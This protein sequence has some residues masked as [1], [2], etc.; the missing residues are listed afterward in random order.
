M[1]SISALGR[2]LAHTSNL[3]TTRTELQAESI[4]STATNTFLSGQKDPVSLDQPDTPTLLE[5]PA[6]VQRLTQIEPT[7]GNGEWN[8][9]L[10]QALESVPEPSG[11]GAASQG[12]GQLSGHRQFSQRAETQSPH[13]NA[14]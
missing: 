5:R 10:Q 3:P 8:K 9:L 7:S 6:P 11:W 4:L 2:P 14:G 12:L 1:D 13:R